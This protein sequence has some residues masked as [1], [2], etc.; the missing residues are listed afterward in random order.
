M[1]SK[2][3]TSLSWSVACASIMACASC[4]A[5]PI[6]QT[7]LTTN[8]EAALPNIVIGMAMPLTNTFSTTQHVA[9]ATSVLV[10]TNDNRSLNFLGQVEFGDH[11]GLTLVPRPDGIDI[12]GGE[13][14]SYDLGGA[15]WQFHS[16][17]KGNGAG[18]TNLTIWL[19]Q[20]TGIPTNLIPAT[21][22]TESKT[23]WFY[24]NPD[25]KP[26]WIATNRVDGGWMTI[27]PGTV[28]SYP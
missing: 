24:A 18:I 27:D 19:L 1:K 28:I 12:F 8:T 10:R 5:A 23:N 26:R 13:G 16:P 7:S 25:G 3:L 2:I 4:C 9:G 6:R 21:S 17:I 20:S 11:I 22:T 15:G 14:L